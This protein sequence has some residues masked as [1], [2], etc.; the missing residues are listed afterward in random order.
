MA[1]PD[2]ELVAEATRATDR[3]VIASGEIATMDDLA[4][5]ER[6]GAAAAV[7]GM[8]STPVRSIQPPLRGSSINDAR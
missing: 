1:G 3:P 4:A 2:L 6:A 7:I 8:R 5:L